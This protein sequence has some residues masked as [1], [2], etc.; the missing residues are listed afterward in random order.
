M[1][2]STAAPKSDSKPAETPPPPAK[3]EK[4]DAKPSSEKHSS[5]RSRSS[6]SVFHLVA[7]EEAAKEEPGAKKDADMRILKTADSAGDR[8]Q[9][10]GDRA[11]LRQRRQTLLRHLPQQRQRHRKSRCNSS[12]LDK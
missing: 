7:F 2:T 8:D 9:G 6:D 11:Q 3:S 1:A 4:D 12:P 5:L 10:W